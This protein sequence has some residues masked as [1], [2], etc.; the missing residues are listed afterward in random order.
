MRDERS[1]R[2]TIS[3]FRSISDVN[4][5]GSGDEELAA[6]MHDEDSTS[7]DAYSAIVADGGAE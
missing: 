3:C 7:Q 5:F 6:E 4:V 1:I 2:R